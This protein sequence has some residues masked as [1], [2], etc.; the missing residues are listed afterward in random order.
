MENRIIAVIPA[1]NEENNIKRVVTGVMKYC[2]LVIIVNDNSTDGTKK[3]ITE[4]K[5]IYS[6]KLEIINNKK[7]MGIGSSMKK[8][9]ILALSKE[10][11]IIIK[12]DGDGQHRPEDIP[13][14]ISKIENENLDLVK[15]NRF[16]NIY[17]V[18]NMPK[19]KIFGNL[20][21]TNIQKIISGNYSIS[22]PN[23]GFLALKTEKIRL[24]NINHLH[25]KYFFENSLSIIFT[26]FNFKIG[27]VGIET[28][29]RDEKSSIPVFVAGLKLIPTFILFLIRKNLITASRSLS[30]N[31]LIFFISIFLTILN[32]IINTTVLWTIIVC[33]IPLYIFVDILN[34]SQF[35]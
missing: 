16:Y 22:D 35:R 6:E 5:N 26:A 3:I 17:S 4:M 13:E 25:N 27:E 11:D 24:I 12:I 23:N 28:I 29:Y 18:S 33:L 15:G 32:L 1:F 19:I 2:Q 14:F 34:H 21:I 31:S 10:S 8:G 20:L 7:N 30:I 9:L